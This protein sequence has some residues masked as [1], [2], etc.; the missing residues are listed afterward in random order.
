MAT[1]SRVVEKTLAVASFVT[2]TALAFVSLIIRT[3]HDLT[4][5]IILAVAQFLTLTA[6]ILGINLK[7]K[8]DA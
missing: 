7:F 1:R 8:S 3:D 4:A 2:A 6:T 5:N